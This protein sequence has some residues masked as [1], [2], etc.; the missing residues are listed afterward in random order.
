[1]NALR[2]WLAVVLL[3]WGLAA[4]APGEIGVVLVHGKQGSPARDMT[5][6]AA[7]LRARGYAVAAP[8]MPW[9]ADRAYAAPYAD[10]LA[11][12]DRAVTGLRQGG[13]GLVLMV[14]FSLGANAALGYA[15]AH[16]GLGGLV[17]LAPGHFPENPLYQRR[18]ARGRSGWWRP[19][20]GACRSPFRTPSRAS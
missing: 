5:Q 19:G 15:A 13:A 17:L 4:A 8:T 14:G 20:R 6:L 12:L 1:M 11:Q 7:A 18:I 16:P 10:A 2:F 3:P 9:A